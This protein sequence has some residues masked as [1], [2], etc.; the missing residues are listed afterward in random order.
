M[1]LGN[2]SIYIFGFYVTYF[3]YLLRTC[4]STCR[5]MLAANQ[6]SEV[7]FAFRFVL[8]RVRKKNSKLSVSL[9][10]YR[11]WLGRKQLLTIC[12]LEKRW[13]IYDIYSR[14]HWSLTF[15]L[16]SES[17]KISIS[18]FFHVIKCVFDLTPEFRYRKSREIDVICVKSE[19]FLGFEGSRHHDYQTMRK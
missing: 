18:S 9:S 16:T 14:C 1:S 13:K 17:R 3:V 8:I 5:R 19:G 10:S 7:H 11:R 4:Y 15:K 6:R 2:A 12:K